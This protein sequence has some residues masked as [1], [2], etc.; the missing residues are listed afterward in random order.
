M[1]NIEPDEFEEVYRLT[2][3]GADLALKIHHLW[4]AGY[5]LEQIADEFNMNEL[6]VRVLYAMGNYAG[7][8]DIDWSS[9]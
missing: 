7:I 1:E 3:E 5:T 4:L 8:F 6:E 2:P 9:L